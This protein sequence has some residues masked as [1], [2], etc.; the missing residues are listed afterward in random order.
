MLFTVPLIRVGGRTWE[1]G[2]G[3]LALAPSP[4]ILQHILLRQAEVALAADDQVVVHCQVQG[5]AG[6]HQGPGQF[7]VGG[8]R[9]E[10]A[11]G[12]VV[13]QDEAG[14]PVLQGQFFLGEFF[15]E[16]QIQAD[17]AGWVGPPVPFHFY[18]DQ[19]Q[20]FWQDSR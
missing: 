4:K 17:L 3:P 11:A 13:H 8:G 19:G 15:E 7:L 9:G 20:E 14:G 2:A 6:L 16:G 18:R 12:V 1:K 10:A 5:V